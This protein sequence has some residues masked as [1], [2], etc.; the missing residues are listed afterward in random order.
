MKLALASQL[1]RFVFIIPISCCQS[2]SYSSW[3]PAKLRQFIQ[4]WN[5]TIHSQILQHTVLSGPCSTTTTYSW[6]WK[7]TYIQVG[8][9]NNSTHFLLRNYSFGKSV[10]TS[11]LCMTQAIFP[12]TVYR[13]IISL[14]IH[15]I[16]IPVGQTFTYTK[17]TVPLNSLENSRKVCNGFRSFW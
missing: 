11:T 8:V 12:T 13:Q 10:K 2:S 17:L 9:I 6:S 16:P 5:F 3:G 4:F 7:F 15:C 14:I 1:D